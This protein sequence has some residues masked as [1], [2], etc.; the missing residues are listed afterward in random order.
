MTKLYVVPASHPCATVMKALELK[1]VPYERVDLVP[2]FHV[3]AQRLR[4]GARTVPG[5]I[6]DDGAKVQGSKP[7]LRELDRR[8]P[9]PTLVTAGGDAAE[10]W[11]DEVL[12]PL[13]RRVIWA[14]LSA[15]TRAQESYIADA[16]LVPPTP[17]A[18]ARA[19]AGGLGWVERKLNKSTPDA[20]RSDLEALPGHL[21]EVDAWI[22]DGTLG[23]ETAAD[24]QVFPSLRLLM[25]LEDLA[26][27]FAG[28]PC[29]EH[30][31][32]LFPVYPGRVSPGAL[33]L[34]A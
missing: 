20:V 23:A 11:G 16:K 33:A 3:A 5:I 6:F 7:I 9:E 1:G 15:D 32:R 34:P 19:T 26:P 30:A 24:L 17:K 4:F 2:A 18:V 22:A 12:Q 31:R 21:D 29:A 8:H 27:M 13:V 14:A 10:T 28:R 25:T